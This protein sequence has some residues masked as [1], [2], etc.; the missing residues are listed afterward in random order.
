MASSWRSEI[1]SYLIV[2]AVALLVWFWA[3]AE[4]REQRNVVCKARFVVPDSD[5]WIIEPAIHAF[6][7]VV[8]GS[9]LSLQNVEQM[10][11][12]EIT[13]N[14]SPQVGEQS[15]D[16]EEALRNDPG[17]RATGAQLVSIERPTASP[18]VD[19]IVTMQLNV[20]PTL[21][22]VQTVAAQPR[23]EPP[24]VTLRLPSRMQDQYADIRAQAFVGQE[25]SSTLPEGVPQQLDI[26]PRLLPEALASNEYVNLSPD[27]VRLS[28][29]IRSQTRE[30]ALNRPVNVQLAMPHQDQRD[31]L[32]EFETDSIRNVMV[33]ADADLVRRIESGEATVI[34][35]VHLKSIE[36]E[37]IANDTGTAERPVSM[38]AAL[39]DGRMREV[40]CNVDGS[41]EPPIIRLTVTNRRGEPPAE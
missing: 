35:L 41:N 5:T 24:Q 17:F 28:F 13:I 16:M 15:V 1:G 8:E 38:F 9:R 25:L 4:T 7:I 26:Q 36:K 2:T 3:A 34:A 31:F 37:R 33:I 10:A 21:P 30:L 40:R 29:T 23:V 19:R 14:L 6:T 11:K 32:V 27:S 20:Q 39:V 12:G 18:T 22:G